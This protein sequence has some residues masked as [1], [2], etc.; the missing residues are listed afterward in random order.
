[1]F[2]L[3]QQTPSCPGLWAGPSDLL[4]P[5]RQQLPSCKLGPEGA[6]KQPVASAFASPPVPTG[7]GATE[8]LAN[9]RLEQATNKPKLGSL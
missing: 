6:Y 1:M 2:P 4:R 5:M 8:L 7:V 9:P 3:G